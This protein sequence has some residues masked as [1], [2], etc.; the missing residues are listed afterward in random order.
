MLIAEPPVFSSPE[1][2]E[3]HP[4]SPRVHGCPPA[5][6]THVH[7]EKFKKIVKDDLSSIASI[8]HPKLS[9]GGAI[10]GSILTAK[11]GRSLREPNT[12]HLALPGLR[13]YLGATTTL[14]THPCQG[15]NRLSRETPC[16][17]SVHIRCKVQSPG[18]RVVSHAPADRRVKAWP[19]KRRA[20]GRQHQPVNRRKKRS[21]RT[22]MTPFKQLCNRLAPHLSQPELA[23][24]PRNY[25]RVGDILITRLAPELRPWEQEIGQA[26]L[27][28]HRWVRVVAIKTE[29]CTGE[30]RTSKLR[31]IAGEPCLDTLHRENGI[32]LRLNPAEVYFSPR[33]ASERLRLSRAITQGERVA[34]LCSGIAPLPLVIACHS[35]AAHVLGVEKNPRAHAFAQENVTLNNLQDKVSLICADVACMNHPKARHHDRVITMLP[36]DHFKLLP[37]ALALLSSGGKLHHYAMVCK[38]E[39]PSVMAAI[40]RACQSAD[41]S[42]GRIEYLRCGHCGPQTYRVCYTLTIR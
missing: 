14:L 34:V 37:T 19:G 21:E 3:L 7:L 36:T 32:Q 24:I 6:I 22:P 27:V 40:S 30:Y 15:N 23:L 20:S 26:Y 38:E 12:L 16:F 31:I 41:R 39:H 4:L 5:N 2:N 10:F 8:G 25:D 42:A 1:P 13:S 33:M 29:P 9:T 35:K 11:S 17:P 18:C 28:V